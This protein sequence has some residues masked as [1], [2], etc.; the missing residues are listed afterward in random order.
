MGMNVL[1]LFDGLSCG[2][3][4]L[5]RAGFTIDKYFASEIEPNVISITQ[6]N[7]PDTIQLGNVF[8]IDVDCSYLP[9]IDIL[10]GGSPCTFWSGSKNHTAKSKRETK[11]EGQGWDL[12]EAYD[13][14]RK[15]VNPTY[16][17]L[18]NNNS[19]SDEIRDEISKRLGVQPILIDSATVAAQTRKRYYWTNIPNV[20]IPED[21]GILFKDVAVYD[22]S[23]YKTDERISK[24]LKYAKTG[25]YVKWDLSGKGHYSQQDRAY[26][27]EGK[28]PTVPR[29]RTETKI[30][31][32]I[33]D[34]TYKKTCPVECE[35][36][37][38]IP[39]EY[40]KYGRLEDGTI[41]EISKTRRF[42]AIGNA[43]TVD[44]ISHILSFIPKEN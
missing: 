20:T 38:T 14:I 41:K 5:H 28:A 10:M 26:F 25:N 12:F 18:E 6:Y 36:L 23:L 27:G 8:D 24:T 16:F 11:P 3:I 13:N 33:N 4:A 31:L 30:N 43:W 35:R 29:C 1:S 40:T 42:E 44:I 17:L 21:K 39:D 15:K 37:Q 9:K 7:Y 2:Q 32:Y 22:P 34:N 19:I